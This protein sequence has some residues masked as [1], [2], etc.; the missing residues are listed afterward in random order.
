MLTAAAATWSAWC[1]FLLVSDEPVPLT[2]PLTLALTL[3]LTLTLTMAQ[4]IP[5]P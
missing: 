2:L 4:K 3:T 5:W 1:V